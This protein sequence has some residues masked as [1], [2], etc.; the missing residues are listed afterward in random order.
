MCATVPRLSCFM[1][2]TA[3]DSA[4]SHTSMHNHTRA[5]LEEICEA[6]GISMSSLHSDAHNV[7][8]LELFMLNFSKARSS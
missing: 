5:A 1:T 4:V 6:N 2:S 3:F 7:T 8:R